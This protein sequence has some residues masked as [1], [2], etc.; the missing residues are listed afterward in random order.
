M[1]LK[2]EF[3][4]N[5]R[6]RTH[7]D[8]NDRERVLVYEYFIDDLLALVSNNPGL[9]IKARKLILRELDWD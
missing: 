2:S 8:Y 7:V 3:G 4:D 5:R 1:E 9:P 6:V